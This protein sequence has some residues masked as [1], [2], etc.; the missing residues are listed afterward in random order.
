MLMSSLNTAVVTTVNLVPTAA[1]AAQTALT[2]V[3]VALTITNRGLKVAD[4][5]TASWERKSLESIA[6]NEKHEVEDAKDA[7]A[8]TRASTKRQ[9][10]LTL[11]ADPELAQLFAEERAKL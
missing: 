2:S 11:A 9:L 3:D 10:R 8:L 6:T 1:H 7:A 5:H 4:A